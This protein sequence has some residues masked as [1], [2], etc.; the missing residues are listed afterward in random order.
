MTI[1]ALTEQA[2]EEA[3]QHT[4]QLKSFRPGQK[5]ALMTLMDQGRLLCIQPTGH[6]KSLLYQLPAILLDGMTVVISPLLA[7]MRDQ[8][9]QL[10]HRFG[11]AAGSMNTDQTEEENASTRQAAILGEL[12]I[13]FISPEQLEHPDRLDFLLHLSVKLIVIDEAHCISTWGH[14]FR[15]GYRQIINLTRAFASKNPDIK[16]LGLTAT[17]PPKIEKDILN[18]LTVDARPMQVHRASMNR[19]NLR[20]SVLTVSGLPEK[21]LTLA[22]I[23]KSLIGN[24]LIYCATRENTELVSEYLQH[25]GVN[26]AAYHAGMATSEKRRIQ[27]KFLSDEY[28]VISAT[29]ALGMGIDKS[30]LRYIIHFDFPGSLTAY[31]QEVGRAGRDGL[32]AVGI[33]LYDPSDRK[34]QQYFME[35]SQ[36]TEADFASVQS[37]V[38]TASVPP[39]LTTLRR[40]TGLHPTRL[41]VVLA[42]LVE[43]GFLAKKTQRGSVIYERISRSGSP[44]LQRYDTQYRVKL[45]EL[46]SMETYATETRQ[47]L[48]A[49]LR[50]ALGDAQAEACQ[51]CSSCTPSA[52]QRDR[53][54]DLMMSVAAW[55]ERRSVPIVL[56]QKLSKVAPGL[57][58]LDA[59]LRSEDFVMFM[60]QRA[61]ASDQTLGI[62]PNL[63]QLL[64]NCVTDLDRHY[65]FGGIV[66]LPSRTWH[67]REALAQALGRF[68]NLP[69]FLNTLTWKSLPTARQGELLN[70]DQRQHNVAR[71][72]QASPPTRMIPRAILLLDDYVGSGA[73][74]T[75]A[76]RALREEGAWTQELVPFTIAAVKWRLGR[77][78]MV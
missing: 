21:L 57:A 28:T 13:L 16:I 23:L 72:L 7:L 17:A 10:K 77:P 38:S 22:S 39:N 62:T 40:L 29:N 36:P 52:F 58:A 55:L 31:Y 56:S 50:R 65:H 69:V 68:L 70:N 33:L 34:I 41:V 49:I 11:I 51:Q 75:E 24:G 76:C 64:K 2:L 4:F 43:Q 45:A 12:R 74:L 37:I 60:R 53:H 42:E 63:W 73:T 15:P 44:N 78:G 54:P 18:Q 14:D 59:K 19:A 3:L 71:Q 1:H 26:I 5:E 6:G 35:A 8:L 25:Q 20:L 30:N 61:Q 67:F 9:F 66:V 46:K 32:P 27:E 48:M 47:C